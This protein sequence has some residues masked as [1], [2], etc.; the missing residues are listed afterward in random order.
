MSEGDP[1]G[2][3]L[4]YL[5]SDMAAKMLAGLI[6]TTE[7]EWTPQE[8][9]AVAVEMAIAVANEVRLYRLVDNKAVKLTERGQD[10]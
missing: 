2:P 9:A 7:K 6:A 4:I 3:Q 8:A 10:A 1:L 5:T